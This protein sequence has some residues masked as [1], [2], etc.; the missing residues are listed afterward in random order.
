MDVLVFRIAL[1][2]YSLR[3]DLQKRFN[4]V[5]REIADI[6]FEGVEFAGFY[7]RDP[8]EL[9]ETLYKIGLDVAG[10]HIPIQAF[11]ESEIDKTISFNAVLGN[12]YLIIP[13]LPEEMRRTKNDWIRFSELL[14]NL[15]K[16]L[17]QYKM[18]IGYHNHAVE[19]I[20]VEDEHPWDIV[21]NRTST[22]VIMQLDIGN[23]LS[24]QIENSDIIDVVKRYRGRAITV[25]AK[26]YSKKKAIELKDIHKGFEVVIGEGDVQWIDILK[27]LKDYG[28]T[29][30]IIVE[31]ETYPYKPPIESIKRSFNNLRDI[32]SIL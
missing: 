18:K 2:L 7:G 6:G 9:R 32:L 10:A 13:G 30:W 20:P 31:Q 16:K 1:Q 3:E 14:N 23:A 8:N 4:D 27:V 11:S 28:G 5:L 25:H 21:F 15:A 17:S 26:E 19:F 29:E 24:A 12:R 22:D